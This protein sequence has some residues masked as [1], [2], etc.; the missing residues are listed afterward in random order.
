M[1][2][3]GSA[4]VR[5]EPL[6]SPWGRE[7]HDSRVALT[8]FVYVFVIASVA[9][10]A[11]TLLSQSRTQSFQ[12]Y[13]THNRVAATVQSGRALPQAA[14]TNRPP[15]FQPMRPGATLARPTAFS[16]SGL[17]W[18]P[19]AGAGTVATDHAVVTQWPAKPSEHPTADASSALYAQSTPFEA[20]QSVPLDRPWM[21]LTEAM[22]WQLFAPPTPCSRPAC[23]F[24]TIAA[25]SPE[26]GRSFL[27][28]PP[29]LRDP[30]TVS[31]TSRLAN[32]YPQ[33]WE[34]L[35]PSLG[36]LWGQSVEFGAMRFSVSPYEWRLSTEMRGLHL[37]T[38]TPLSTPLQWF[39]IE[40]SGGVGVRTPG[41]LEVIRA[42]GGV[43]IF[44]HLSTPLGQVFGGVTPHGPLVGGVFTSGSLT[45]W[46][47][48][49]VSD[50]QVKVAGTIALQQGN[51][52]LAYT[53]S[54][55]NRVVSGRYARGPL[56]LAVAMGSSETLVR[57]SYTPALGTSVLALWSNQTGLHLFAVGSFTFG[58]HSPVRL[59]ESP[60]PS[61]LGAAS[62]Q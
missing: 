59:Q 22:P 25:S 39:G 23:Q 33:V 28:L 31:F 56:D 18:T 61:A 27:P 12:P 10:A 35:V 29:M 2:M 4:N 16:E 48:T 47:A 8:P 54:T 17:A 43:Q 21:T 32:Q 49:L 38:A 58:S 15:I 19:R 57:L 7:A 5:W 26:G 45:A 3:N 40:A 1:L 55:T 46:V 9:L 34:L 41:G 36:G 13:W 30:W 20:I 62:N 51:V 60:A 50:G 37:Y 52:S 11:I 44:Q 42:S 6:A 14:Q 53:D 24:P